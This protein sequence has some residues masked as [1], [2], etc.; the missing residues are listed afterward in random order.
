M[1]GNGLHGGDGNL[2]A[3]AF[4]LRM[5]AADGGTLRLEIGQQARGHA[6]A[7]VHQNPAASQKLV[8]RSDFRRVR[9]WGIPAKF[10][11]RIKQRRGDFFLRRRQGA[12]LGLKGGDLRQRVG[13]R[14]RAGINQRIGRCHIRGQPRG[15][16]PNAG[17]QRAK[18]CHHASGAAARIE[19]SHR[20]Q[21]ADLNQVSF[22]KEGRNSFSHGGGER[23]MEHSPLLPQA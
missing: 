22:G 18:P 21:Q 13:Q 19:P 14:L 16:Q 17:H 15:C 23:V 6:G 9:A 8:I 11:Q 7:N 5:A 4:V 1:G 2:R 3:D 12:C 10:A 20:N